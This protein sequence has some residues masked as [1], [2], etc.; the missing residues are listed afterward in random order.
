MSMKPNR[1]TLEANSKGESVERANT[2]SGSSNRPSS[3][4]MRKLKEKYFNFSSSCGIPEEE[5]RSERNEQVL[6]NEV[7]REGNVVSYSENINPNLKTPFNV[8]KCNH[9]SGATISLDLTKDETGE[10]DYRFCASSCFTCSPCSMESH[11]M[12]SL[13][14]RQS[15]KAF[16]EYFNSETSWENFSFRSSNLSYAT[17]SSDSTITRDK[18]DNNNYFC[19][20]KNPKDFS[21][22]GLSY[23]SDKIISPSDQTH[24]L[25][26]KKYKNDEVYKA[27]LVNYLRKPSLAGNKT[28]TNKYLLERKKNG[29]DGNLTKYFSTFG[30][31]RRKVTSEKKVYETEKA[32]FDNRAEFP[33]QVPEKMPPQYFKCYSDRQIGFTSR[34]QR[35]LKDAE[36]DDDVETDSEQLY[37]AG[38]HIMK[39]LG[40]GIVLFNKN[41]KNVRNITLVDEGKIERF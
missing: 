21:D 1:V 11:T 22:F 8:P 17:F 38:R 36:M 20:R 5:V 13:R 16:P 29:F 23:N 37:A 18:R 3:G 39:E 28:E 41:R 33:F 14:S 19:L 12:Q 10:K 7:E 25:L 9:S 40:E 24:S 2:A 32:F 35:Q 30:M 15:R 27:K 34:W 6:S 4:L 26:P 31:K